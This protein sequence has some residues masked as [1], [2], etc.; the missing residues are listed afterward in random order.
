VAEIEPVG[1]VRQKQRLGYGRI[2]LTTVL[3]KLQEQ[4]IQTVRLGVWANNQTA[5]HLYRALGFQHH[6]SSYSLTYT[7]NIK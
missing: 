7:L 6:S 4:N 5:V 1:I 3:Q 2:L